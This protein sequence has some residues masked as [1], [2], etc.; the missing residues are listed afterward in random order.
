MNVSAF[1]L[2]MQQ[3]T[4]PENNDFKTL[5]NNLSLKV[6]LD[7]AK[8]QLTEDVELAEP[9][10]ALLM[11]KS[12][13]H[14][15]PASLKP[16]PLLTTQEIADLYGLLK[17]NNSVFSCISSTDPDK[18]RAK[19]NELRHSLF[20]FNSQPVEDLDA[21]DSDDEAMLSTDLNSTIST[22]QLNQ[23]KTDLGLIAEFNK[24]KCLPT[25]APAIENT[26]VHG[27]NLWSVMLAIILSD[28][29]LLGGSEQ[30]ETSPFITTTGES[31][32]E[33]KLNES[34]VS[35]ILSI[36]D[37][38]AVRLGA[39]NT[40]TQ[41]IPL[42]NLDPCQEYAKKATIVRANHNVAAHLKFMSGGFRYKAHQFQEK[43]PSIEDK[44][45]DTNFFKNTY[46]ILSKLPVVVSGHPCGETTWVKSSIKGE[47]ACER[48]LI[49][50]IFVDTKHLP[51]IKK[52]F[53][54]LNLN[55]ITVHEMEDLGQ[56][57][58]T[59]KDGAMP[60]LIKKI[61]DDPLITPSEIFENLQSKLYTFIEDNNAATVKNFV[62]ALL[63]NPSLA[64]ADKI[65]LLTAN[66]A[67][68]KRMWH[69]QQ[70]LSPLEFAASAAKQQARSGFIEALKDSPLHESIIA[71]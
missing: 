41:C 7:K 32:G 11:G 2:R 34:Y 49:T 15:L 58:F 27:T 60:S 24:F 36:R 61:I 67:T 62:T 56:K 51:V 71:Q 45:L 40:T 42:V 21:Y 31:N 29:H 43:N 50:D 48:V 6:F 22:L 38:A 64:T 9:V 23:L 16:L 59:T 68:N 18:A 39:L 17:I 66:A 33:T 69:L 10:A 53:S 46:G 47:L 8:Q 28:K 54:E 35:T 57:V 12:A 37:C 55:T 52:I 5:K 20:Y 70:T 65:K 30:R 63:E 4:L 44:Y 1:K 3:F 13:G 25:L 19:L 26:V 14:N